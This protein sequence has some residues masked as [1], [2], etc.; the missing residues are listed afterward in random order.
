VLSNV[1]HACWPVRSGLSGGPWRG[2]SG[3]SI[4]Y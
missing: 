3:E 1:K 2:M 4:F